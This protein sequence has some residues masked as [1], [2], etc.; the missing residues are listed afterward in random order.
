[1]KTLRIILIPAAA[2]LLLAL[3]VAGCGGGGSSAKLES[4]DVAVV[5]QSQIS[6]TQFDDLMATAQASFKQ[7]GRA[8][9]KQGTTEYATIKSQ[10][11]T[12][13][14][15]QTERDAK[16]KDL[17]IEITDKQIDDRLKQ[18]KQQYF[19]GDDK[20]YKAQ[21]KKQGL[22]EEQVRSDIRTQLVSEQ[23]FNTVTKD[24]RV[25]DADVHQYYVAHADQFKQPESRE[26]R[27]I[28][29]KK[30]SL[31]DSIYQQLKNGGNFAKLAKKYSLD[32]VSAAQGGNYHAVKGQ[33]VAPFDKV[34]FQ[35]K[36]NEISKPV[37][38]Q[39]GWHVIQALSPIHPAGTTPEKQAAD[40]IRQQLLQT[41]K[42]DAVNTWAKD[43][44][45]SYCKD[46]RIKYQTGFQPSP[47]PCAEPASTTSTTAG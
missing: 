28:L 12:L 44:Q 15:Q 42:Q 9:P 22:S 35:L 32:T 21:L 5:G 8:F 18:I 14:V 30:K 41:K 45:K 1:M 46:S 19:Q 31:A 17:G 20:A 27:H 34:A 39:Y 13:L 24:V 16:A 26:V 37:Q 23:L 25:T 11:V 38:T 29:V 7:Q 2:V 3:A 4:S 10:A 6:R 36:T 40:Q 47:D 43:I 33:S